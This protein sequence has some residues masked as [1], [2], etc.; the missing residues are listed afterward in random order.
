M[1]FFDSTR[2]PW[3][4]KDAEF[5]EANINPAAEGKFERILGLWMERKRGDGKRVIGRR[6]ADGSGE[7][8]LVMLNF[9]GCDLKVDLNVGYQGKW[10]KLADIDHLVNTTNG[11]MSRPQNGDRDSLIAAVRGHCA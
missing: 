10:V 8:I 4:D 2:K 5:Q 3:E 11:Q 1:P 6:A 9:E 7:R